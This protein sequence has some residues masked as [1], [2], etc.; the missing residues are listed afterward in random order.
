LNK[1][2][3]LIISSEGVNVFSSKLFRSASP[4]YPLFL[5]FVYPIMSS[6]QSRPCYPWKHIGCLVWIGKVNLIPILDI[7][8]HIRV[9]Y[10]ME[11]CAAGC[12]GLLKIN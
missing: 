6:P 8:P 1:L 7:Y 12:M 5:A 9:G 11:S 3:I 4:P 2:A 10:D